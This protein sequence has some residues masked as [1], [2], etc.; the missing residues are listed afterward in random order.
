MKVMFQFPV[1]SLSLPKAFCLFVDF[2]STV[3]E[4][5][6]AVPIHLHRCLEGA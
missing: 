2:K 5:L 1:I 4:A 6:C 3:V